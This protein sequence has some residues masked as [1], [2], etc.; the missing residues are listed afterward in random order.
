MFAPTLPI[1]FYFPPLPEGVLGICKTVPCEIEI[2]HACSTRRSGLERSLAFL[3]EH[4]GKSGNHETASLLFPHRETANCEFYNFHISPNV[5]LEKA[6]TPLIHSASS[7]KYVG[8][9]SREEWPY[10]WREM[11]RTPR[12]TRQILDFCVVP[13]SAGTH[14]GV[15]Q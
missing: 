1:Y 3:V 6:G 7:S 15:A 4:L 8:F 2:C 12:E 13:D 11:T 9:Q 5:L 10:R 14:H